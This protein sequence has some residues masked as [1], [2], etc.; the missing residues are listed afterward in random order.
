M[1]ES[2]TLGKFGGKFWT[3]MGKG[4]IGKREEKRGGK[5]K[6]GKKGNCK[7]GGENLKWKGKDMSLFGTTENNYCLGCTKM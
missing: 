6:R 1:D 2:P 3:T 7:R 5:E 4:G